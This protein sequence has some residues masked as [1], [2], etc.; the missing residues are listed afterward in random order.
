MVA[1]AQ[2]GLEGAAMEEMGTIILREYQRSG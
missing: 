1:E 2:E